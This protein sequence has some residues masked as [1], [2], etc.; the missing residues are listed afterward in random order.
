MITVH[1]VYVLLR[2]SVDHWNKATW[3]IYFI[4]SLPIFTE[5]RDRGHHRDRSHLYFDATAIYWRDAA[6]FFTTPNVSVRLRRSFWASLACS[7]ESSTSSAWCCCWVT[8]TAV[9]SSSYLCYKT[10]RL[11]RGLPSIT[12]R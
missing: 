2:L 1:L 12:S 9:C 3:F 6:T 11:T 8:G 4:L 5:T 10:S 7:C